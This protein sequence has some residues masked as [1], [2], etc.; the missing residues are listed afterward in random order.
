MA[1]ERI[2]PFG[3]LPE[4]HRSAMIACVIANANRSPKSPAKKMMDFMPD[5]PEVRLGFVKEGPK[6]QSLE[7]QKA[8]VYAI[9]EHAKRM[10]MVIRSRKDKGK[11][12]SDG[13]HEHRDA[14]RTNR[15]RHQRPS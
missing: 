13:G 12:Q 3:Q 1:Y 8:M 4:Y 7:E 9:Y 15:R 10:G 2:E 11:E 5:P 6:V 14:R